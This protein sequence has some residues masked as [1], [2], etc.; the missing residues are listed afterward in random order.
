MA[1]FGIATQ[2]R[3]A[4]LQAQCD[5]WN[6]VNPVGREVTLT[7]DNGEQLQTKTRSTAQVLS[8]HTAVIWVDGVAG[9]YLLDR[10]R[11]VEAVAV[12]VTWR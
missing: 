11:V 7:R 9:C 10:V 12:A 2:R 6:A 8:G 5:A 3:V 1:R 4:K